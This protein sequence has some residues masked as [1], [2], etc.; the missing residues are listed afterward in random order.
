MVFICENY[1]YVQYCLINS[2]RVSRN[3]ILFFIIYILHLF[4]FFLYGNLCFNYRYI[5]Y[6]H[7]FFLLS[8]LISEQRLRLLL[9]FRVFVS[10][11]LKSHRRRFLPADTIILQNLPINLSLFRLK[12][13]VSSCRRLQ[14][15]KAKTR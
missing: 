9:P 13:I 4:N 14:K 6:F 5:E 8:F 15:S 1:H 3:F 11:A 12:Y 7:F 2:D 10:S